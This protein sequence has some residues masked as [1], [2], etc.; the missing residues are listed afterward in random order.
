[1]DLT[2]CTVQ[3][4][5]G[6][7]AIFLCNDANYDENKGIIEKHVK[8]IDKLNELRAEINSASHSRTGYAFDELLQR[9]TEA[10][11]D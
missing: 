1:M 4:N 11:Q 10:I 7:Y 8:R 2:I 9:Y 6:E 5:G 3:A